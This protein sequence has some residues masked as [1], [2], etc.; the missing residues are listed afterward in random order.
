MEMQ[1]CV[2]V[3]ERVGSRC[4]LVDDDKKKKSQRRNILFMCVCIVVQT[5]EVIC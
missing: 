1:R 3:K 2:K 5:Q 4:L